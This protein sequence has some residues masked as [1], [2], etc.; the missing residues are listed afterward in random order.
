MQP[1]PGVGLPIVTPE[2][3]GGPAVHLELVVD[4]AAGPQVDLLAE[5]GDATPIAWLASE[6]RYVEK[7]ATPDVTIADIIGVITVTD[8]HL[9]IDSI[10][11]F[12]MVTIIDIIATVVDNLGFLS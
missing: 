7:L 10:T 1:H 11:N 2:E 3:A 8:I 9:N 5:K 6:Q 4:L 12:V